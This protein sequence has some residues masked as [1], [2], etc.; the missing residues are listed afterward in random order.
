MEGRTPARAPPSSEHVGPGP[1][2]S[3][4]L[5]RHA[6]PGHPRVSRVSPCTTGLAQTSLLPL[7]TPPRESGVVKH[8]TGMHVGHVCTRM[9]TCVSVRL[10]APS[11]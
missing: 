3:G 8:E 6:G 11:T 10:R 5:L 1:S 7:R 2:P 9:H 4:H